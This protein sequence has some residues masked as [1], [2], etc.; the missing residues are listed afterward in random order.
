MAHDTVHMAFLFEC[1]GV[2]IIG[3]QKE[4]ARIQ[5]ALGD[6]AH[7]LGNVMPC[8]AKTHHHPH[9]LT[10]TSD[11]IFHARSFVIILGTA[12]GISVERQ[13]QVKRGIMPPD[14]FARGAGNCH[15]SVHL[16]ITVKHAG[17]IHH[18]AQTDDTGPVNCFGN[19]RRT[20]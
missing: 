1:R 19:F 14:D 20:N 15:L 8:G 2:R 7:L 16:C 11:G 3:A 13:A 9:A 6:S 18:L 12:G 10:G 5:T 17:V 4:H